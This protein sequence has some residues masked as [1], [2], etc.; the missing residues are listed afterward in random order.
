MPWTETTRHQY[1]RHNERYS[2]DVTDEDRAVIFPL[3]PSPDKSGRP[4]EIELRDV[5]DG[6]GD[7][8]AAGGA[9]SLLPKDFPPVSTGSVLFPQLA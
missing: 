5:W 8:A 2:S 9:W 4:Q 7:I 6:I 1:E 3:L